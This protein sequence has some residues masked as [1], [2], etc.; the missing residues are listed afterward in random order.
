[1]PLDAARHA[2]VAQLD[3]A[4]DYESEGQRFES[5]RARH[6]FF[7][8]LITTRLRCANPQSACLVR[9]F[10]QSFAHTKTCGRKNQHGG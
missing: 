4:S 10:G 5:F 7:H 1:M 6:F 2:P 9:A 3:R 8:I